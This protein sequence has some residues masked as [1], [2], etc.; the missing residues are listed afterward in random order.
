MNR[1]YS[2]GASVLSN[3]ASVSTSFIIAWLSVG[4]SVGR[5]DGRRDGLAVCLC[6]VR[7]FNSAVLTPNVSYSHSV[8]GWPFQI[9][10]PQQI[11]SAARVSSGVNS[12]NCLLSVSGQSSGS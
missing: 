4:D 2:V 3:N 7:K 5:S 1:T 11:L 6:F 8:R 9:S 10:T 12:S